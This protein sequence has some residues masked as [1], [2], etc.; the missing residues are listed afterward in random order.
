[1]FRQLTFSPRQLYSTETVSK[2]RLLLCDSENRLGNMDTE[3]R[4]PARMKL[5]IINLGT[6]QRILGTNQRIWERT[7]GRCPLAILSVGYSIRW[8]YYALVILSVVYSYVLY[9]A[10]SSLLF[11]LYVRCSMVLSFVYA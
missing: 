10:L 4:A 5:T 6:N 11:F 7:N 8:L 9:N 2:K 3:M 1:M